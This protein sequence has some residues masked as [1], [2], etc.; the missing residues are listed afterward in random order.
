VVAVEALW[1]LI[2]FEWTIVVRCLLSLVWTAAIHMVEICGV[3]RVEVDQSLWQTA[4]Q[5][6]RAIWVVEVGEN[7]PMTAV[8]L[9]RARKG[10]LWVVASLNRWS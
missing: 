10:T 3:S 8:R 4:H 6:R 1:A 7:R 2:T 9:I 5:H